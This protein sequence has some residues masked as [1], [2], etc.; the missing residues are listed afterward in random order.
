MP[1]HNY[2]VLCRYNYDPLDRL[3]GTIP[4]TDSALQHFYC[5]SRLVTEIQDTTQR[6]VFFQS[7][8]ILA[9]HNRQGNLVEPLLLATDVMHSVLCAII[10]N[11]IRATSYSPYGYCPVGND[12]LNLP[13]FNGERLDRVTGSYLLG[14]GYRAFN[15]VVMRFNRCDH[16]SPFKGGGINPYAY[17]L[18]DPINRFDENGHVSF[19]KYMKALF[20]PKTFKNLENYSVDEDFASFIQLQKTTDRPLVMRIATAEDLA[21]L[22][23][24]ESAKFVFTKDKE[25]ILGLGI[26]HRKLMS[27]SALTGN[28]KNVKVISAGAIHKEV[29]GSLIL[30]NVSGHYRPSS[31][32][33]NYV[34]KYIEKNNIGR[35]SELIRTHK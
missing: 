32:S 21:K 33:L 6:S 25:L 10:K 31:K 23:P 34:K 14:C 24:D 1:G 18:G 8:Q 15:P 20:K 4:S 29:D 13:G 5:G 3:V 28:A 9:Q 27:H 17:C 2:D 7:E 12:L 30:N 11:G 22:N 19:F 16:M 26:K 35:V